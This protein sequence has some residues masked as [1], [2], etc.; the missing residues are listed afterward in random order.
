[1]TKKNL[2]PRLF[3]QFSRNRYW[4]LIVFISLPV[5]IFFV[6]PFLLKIPTDFSYQAD[7]VSVDNFYDE[8]TGDYQGEQYSNTQFSYHIV[9]KK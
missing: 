5:W 3:K 7:I 4:F 6:A 8:K 9:D 2:I 1:M